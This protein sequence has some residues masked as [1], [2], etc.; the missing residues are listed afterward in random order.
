MGKV[1]TGKICAII[2]LIV[3]VL[4]MIANGVYFA[5]QNQ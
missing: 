2:G 4:N 5:M 1:N 3:S